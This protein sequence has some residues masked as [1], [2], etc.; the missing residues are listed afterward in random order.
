[1]NQKDF[2]EMEN[3]L[4]TRIAN[5][6]M[7]NASFQDNLGIYQGKMGCVL[8]FAHYSR[9]TN[10]LR[11]AEFASEL[12]D[13]IYTDLD[14]RVPVDFAHGLCGIAWGIEHLVQLSFTQADTGEIL[15]DLN[16]KIMERDPLRIH[17]LSFEKGLE[18]IAYYIT[19]HTHSPYAKTKTIA[20]NYLSCLSTALTN[21]GLAGINLPRKALSLPEALHQKMTTLNM[22]NDADLSTYPLGI[23][24]GLAGMGLK[25]M[26][27]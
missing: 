14:E 22:A 18:G 11:Y 15:E 19:V 5:Y 8:F 12:L 10:Q 21:A 20:P 6:L 27:L 16:T 2:E 17:D 25:I 26:G 9:Y 23:V 4:L 1:M 3:I 13:E 7:M 24:E